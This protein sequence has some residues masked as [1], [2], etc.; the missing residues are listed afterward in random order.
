MKLCYK[1]NHPNMCYFFNTC[2][3]NVWKMLK[4]QRNTKDRNSVLNL[5]FK[6]VIIKYYEKKE[7]RPCNF[8]SRPCCHSLAGISIERTWEKTSASRKEKK[9]F[10]VWCSSTLEG[11]CKLNGIILWG[12]FLFWVLFCLFVCSVFFFLH[13]DYVCFGNQ[14]NFQRICKLYFCSNLAV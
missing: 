13:K 3:E 5:F 2:C 14:R 6:I 10:H 1:Y 7:S 11:V 8:F 9:C 4:I 12:F